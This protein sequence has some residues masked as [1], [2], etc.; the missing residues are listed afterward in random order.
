M[1][2]PGVDIRPWLDTDFSLLERLLGDPAMM[3]FLGGPESADKLR[4]RHQ[5]YLRLDGS[6]DSVFTIVVGTEREAVGWVGY[7]ESEWQGQTVWETGW[8]VLREFQGRGIA[9]AATARALE[10]ARRKRKHRYVHALPSVENSASNAVCR[11]LGFELLG[12]VDIEYPPGR[13]M[14]ANDWRFDLEDETGK[15]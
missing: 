2:G 6:A 9:T 11:K 3:V 10:H 5:R 4:E 12:E 13:P 1:S 8:H 7:W 15:R 14:R